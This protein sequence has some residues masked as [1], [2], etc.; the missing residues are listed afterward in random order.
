MIRDPDEEA[1]TFSRGD[2]KTGWLHHSTA[3]SGFTKTDSWLKRDLLTP[4]EMDSEKWRG[5]VADS[6]IGS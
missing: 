3:K 6:H 2:A 1:H 5:K 4:Y